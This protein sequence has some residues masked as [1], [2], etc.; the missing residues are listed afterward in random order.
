MNVIV[1]LV[2][3]YSALLE[4]VTTLSTYIAAAAVDPT[5]R[6]GAAAV[7]VVENLTV[8]VRPAY[9]LVTSGQTTSFSA[10]AAAVEQVP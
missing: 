5:F 3:Q 8:T 1:A 10:V 9:R 2:F 6:V 4:D 7:F